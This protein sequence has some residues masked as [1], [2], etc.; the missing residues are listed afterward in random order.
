MY[1]IKYP[2]S[3]IQLTIPVIQKFY[4][5]PAGGGKLHIMNGGGRMKTEQRHYPQPRLQY[6]A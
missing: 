2:A 4:L 5:L 6:R 1:Q 3:S